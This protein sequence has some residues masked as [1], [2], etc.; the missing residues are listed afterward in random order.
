MPVCPHRFAL[1]ALAASLAVAAP[2]AAATITV[3][4]TT[5]T[6]A[7]AILAAN[8]DTDTGGC[9][10]SGG[11]GADVITLDADVT[12]TAADTTNS[13]LFGGA[14]AGLPKIS[15]S[16]TIQAGAGRVIQRDPSYGCA[17]SDAHS[18]RL[19]QI[20]DAST[21]TITLQGLEL[22]HGCAA[23][24]DASSATASGGAI[25]EG[26]KTTLNVTDCV[27]EDNQVWGSGL[28]SLAE[29]G[30][31]VMLGPSTGSS[32]TFTNTRFLDNRAQ[33]RADNS[34]YGVAQ[35]GALYV[36]SS[37]TASLSGCVFTGN[38][39]SGGSGGLASPVYG[40][41]VAFGAG[42]SN[43]TSIDGCTFSGNQATAGAD[44]TGQGA[45]AYGGAIGYLGTNGSIGSLTDSI[46]E[47]N[48]AQGGTGSAGGGAAHGG[49]V[50]C[51]GSCYMQNVSDVLFR[52]NQ[53]LGGGGGTGSGGAA[54][55]GGLAG[56]D[57]VAWDSVTFQDNAAKGGAGASGGAASGGA[58]TF[59]YSSG[60]VFANFTA[61]GNLA[62]GG[63]ATTA[64]AAG[65]A[66]GG[67]F[68]TNTS[69]TFRSITVADN[70][71]AGGSDPGSGG[72]AGGGGIFFQ[73]ITAT[74]SY[75]VASGNSASTGG[76]APSANDC[77]EDTSVTSAGANV[78]LAAGACASDFTQPTDELGVDPQLA[79]LGDYG[80]IA[81]LPDGSCLPAI[82]LDLTSTA[83][84]RGDCTGLGTRDA[85]GF[86][87]EVDRGG[88][89]HCDSGAFEMQNVVYVD[90][91]ATGTGDGVTWTNAFTSL[92]DA[93]DTFN[94]PSPRPLG[95]VGDVRD[96]I[97]IAEGVYRPDEG[98]GAVADDPAETFT[99][100]FDTVLYGGFF[101]GATSVA[102]RDPVA[103]PTVLSGDIDENDTVDADGVTSTYSDIV[104]TNAYHLITFPSTPD[105]SMSLNG[106]VLTGGR[107]S[108]GS[109]GDQR[110]ADLLCTTG[111]TV[112]LRNLRVV[113][114]R[115]TSRAVIY[116][117][118]VEASDASFENN[119]SSDVGAIMAG[120][121]A[122]FARTL[123]SGNS[124]D[125]QAA[126]F[127]FSASDLL[128]LDSA[129]VGNQSGGAAGAIRTFGTTE[130]TN[131]AFSGNGGS[132]PGTVAWVGAG[133]D[134]TLTN[135]TVSGNSSA[136]NGAIDFQS[137]G[138]LAVRN[139][140]LWNNRTGS[141]TGSLDASLTDGGS[142]TVEIRN[143]ILQGSGGSG[144]WIP[145]W[146]D[147]GGNL[148]T[149]PLFVTEVDPTTAPTTTGDLRLRLAS[150][151]IDAGDNAVV[152]TTTD[153]DGDARITGPAVD[154]GP[155]ERPGELFSDGFETGNDCLWSAQVGG[156]CST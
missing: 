20:D 77:S 98:L 146:T 133:G 141:T 52:G 123:F 100:G 135:V 103:H 2:A 106:L 47:D 129:V 79:P 39:A 29:G 99:V 63:D 95:A 49:A 48:V 119:H 134:L 155:W 143:S 128:L 152:T 58:M 19:L 139:S 51:E 24:D 8:A 5:C 67:A 33:G 112:T 45:T 137:T 148:D 55:G 12:L 150:P 60:A 144:G 86:A 131:V 88:V 102:D 61:S 66:F 56:S 115:M 22:R 34:T 130:L 31:V 68:Y 147:G 64:N 81:Q 6:L 153:L 70:R 104:G 109:S 116:G 80:C 74:V 107:A 118:N 92:R 84:D 136:S 114:N 25:F 117:C 125:T 69:G 124:A 91:S 7:N 73:G 111:G 101:A 57:S 37:T 120:G 44:S 36:D 46:F 26:D 10:G 140:I 93:L 23:P 76:G 149:D 96:E 110:G 42:D 15:G 71:A 89:T 9:T 18:F 113:G 87:R 145:S 97:W 14:Y 59:R 27:F 30:A 85:R 13:N 11:Y 3:D 28:G 94:P 35:G 121:N 32:A 16:L 38:L 78:L 65:T 151:A 138:R 142:G 40:G 83:I 82:A 127:Y 4:G 108:G 53:A 1:L 156:G 126:L 17:A 43:L 41:A 54:I 154:M 62:Q 21:K 50:A 75:L 122:R 105:A 90:A 72:A 132:G